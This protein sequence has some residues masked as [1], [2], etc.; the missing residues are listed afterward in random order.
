MSGDGIV[1]RDQPWKPFS[2]DDAPEMQAKPAKRA[3]SSESDD[4]AAL[5]QQLASTESAVELAREYVLDRAA[6]ETDDFYDSGACAEIA[7]QLLVNGGRDRLAAYVEAW[8][9]EDPEMAEAW[10]AD[11]QAHLEATVWANQQ[12]ELASAHHHEIAARAEAAAAFLEKHPSPAGAAIAQA[13]LGAGPS[14]DPEASVETMKEAM[15]SADRAMQAAEFERQTRAAFREPRFGDREIKESVPEV[16]LDDVAPYVKPLPSER[17]A[18]SE[19]AQAEFREAFAESARSPFAEGMKQV[20]AEGRLRQ[21]DE[22]DLQAAKLRQAR[23]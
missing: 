14:D 23:R 21:A 13:A 11:R 12:V 1:V 7:D 20:R 6:Y 22:F 2:W 18:R 19:A 5:R 3:A 8:A 17:A 4:V 10:A 16:S 15:R 9:D